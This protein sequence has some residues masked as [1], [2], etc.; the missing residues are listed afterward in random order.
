MKF[1]KSAQNRIWKNVVHNSKD[2]ITDDTVQDQ[3]T[4]KK[5]KAIC[6]IREDDRLNQSRNEDVSCN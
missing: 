3:D 6:G 2:W 4:P 5:N 1:W